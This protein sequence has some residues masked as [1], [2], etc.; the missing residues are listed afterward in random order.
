MKTYED[1]YLEQLMPLYKKQEELDAEKVRRLTLLESHFQ[2]QLDQ[3][4]GQKLELRRNCQRENDILESMMRELRQ[5]STP[6]AATRRTELKRKET[7][8][9]QERDSAIALVEAS[10]RK[11]TAQNRTDRT[12]LHLDLTEKRCRLREL[13][14]ARKKDHG[15]MLHEAIVQ[16]RQQWSPLKRWIFRR[17]FWVDKPKKGGEV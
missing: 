5:D 10:I 17:F 4:Y 6:E 9:L 2:E 7:Q 11:V 12:R 13:I 16:E 15:R 8:N 14:A 3:L 1:F